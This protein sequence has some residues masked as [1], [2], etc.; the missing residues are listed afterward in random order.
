MSLTGFGFA[1]Y[2]LCWHGSATQAKM[3]RHIIKKHLTTFIAYFSSQQSGLLGSADGSTQQQLRTN[4]K[5]CP[6]S[7]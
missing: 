3:N 2:I 4:N 5:T 7:A 1:V 6:N